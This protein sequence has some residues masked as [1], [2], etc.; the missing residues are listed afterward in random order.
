MA[1]ITVAVLELSLVD[2]KMTV[3]ALFGFN[4]GKGSRKDLLLRAEF[5]KLCLFHGMAF[6]AGDVVVLALKLEALVVG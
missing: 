2:I 5:R 1:G 3:S 6:L 4:R